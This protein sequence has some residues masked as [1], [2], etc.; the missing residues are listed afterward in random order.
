MP[1]SSPAT[2]DRILD[3]AA[4]AAN[5]LHDVATAS[6][7]PFLNRVCTVTLTIIP[8]VQVCNLDFFSILLCNCKCRIPGSNGKDVFVLWRG[9]ITRSVHLRVCQFI[10]TTF[11]PRRCLST[12]HNM[13]GEA[14]RSLI[15][16]VV[17]HLLAIA[18]LSKNLIHV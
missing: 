7:I 1:P 12:L 17:I 9:F 14:C 5:V 11:W 16:P 4:V 10:R 18:A 6:G 2:A 15:L 3:Y 8:M 13:L